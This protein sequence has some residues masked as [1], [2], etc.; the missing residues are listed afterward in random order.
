MEAAPED[1]VFGGN[2]ASV[3][4]APDKAVSSGGH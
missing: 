4:G 3:R 1:I 2:D